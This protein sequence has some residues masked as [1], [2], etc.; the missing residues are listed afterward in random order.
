MTSPIDRC[1]FIE[2]FDESVNRVPHVHSFSATVLVT[3]SLLKAVFLF[4]RDRFHQFVYKF[5]FRFAGEIEAFAVF[6]IEL[7]DR[8]LPQ[9][10]GNTSRS[11]PVSSKREI[12]C[13]NY[14][15][16]S[17]RVYRYLGNRSRRL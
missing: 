15:R 3:P 16:L 6:L 13:R 14:I 7:V 10:F 8:L 9:A 17:D 5:D 11:S 12:Y 4:L 2:L 1:V